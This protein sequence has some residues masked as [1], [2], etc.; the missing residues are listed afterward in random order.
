MIPVN[1][2]TDYHYFKLK[3]TTLYYFKEPIDSWKSNL[4]KGCVG[5][6]ESTHCYIPRLTAHFIVTADN[7]NTVPFICMK[8]IK[9]HAME[10][11]V[12]IVSLFRITYSYD[13]VPTQVK[14][15]FFLVKLA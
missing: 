15:V 3:W 13:K 11:S 1:Y 14:Q 6:S 9:E 7:S 8:S 10:Y 2:M 12:D 4:F 5:S